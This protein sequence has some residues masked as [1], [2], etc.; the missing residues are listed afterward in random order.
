MAG[1]G[2]AKPLTPEQIAQQLAQQ[3]M[4][5]AAYATQQRTSIA[6]A[7]LSGILAGLYSNPEFLSDEFG[8]KA[9]NDAIAFADKLQARLTMDAQ[10]RVKEL[11]PTAVELP[12]GKPADLAAEGGHQPDRPQPVKAANEVS[13]EKT[14][15][16]DPAATDAALKAAT[17]N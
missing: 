3:R 1:N 14:T 7:C 16:A 11:I 17:T 5:A 2:Q 9:I 12:T 4:M 10:A 8:D 15:V 6:T 13:D